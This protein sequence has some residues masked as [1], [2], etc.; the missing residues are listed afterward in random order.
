[1]KLTIEEAMVKGYHGYSFIVSVGE[2]FLI[3]KKRGDRGPA[4]RVTEDG[5]V[6]LA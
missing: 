4:L 5:L 1:M 6:E 3:K 2:K